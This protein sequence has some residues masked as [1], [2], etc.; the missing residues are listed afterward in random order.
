MFLHNLDS[1]WL[2]PRTAR[3]KHQGTSVQATVSA[4]PLSKITCVEY[5]VSGNYEVLARQADGSY[6]WIAGS[7]NTA[8]R[9]STGCEADP[10][11]EVSI[12]AIAE[13]RATYTG[14]TY[15]L[16]YRI[17]YIQSASPCPTYSPCDPA[18][19]ARG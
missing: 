3:S 9:I 13:Y 6:S 2:L 11:A 17:R 14:T 1:S 5:L 15:S 4:N 10:A 18:S 12:D 19:T 16:E 8:T 7:V